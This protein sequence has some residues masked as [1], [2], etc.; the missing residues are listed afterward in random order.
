MATN[1]KKKIKENRNKPI[2]FYRAALKTLNRAKALKK[3]IKLKKNYSPQEKAHITKAFLE[4]TRHKE[5]YQ[6]VSIPRNKG[7]S[8]SHYRKRLSSFQEKWGVKGSLLKGVHVQAPDYIRV[9]YSKGKIITEKFVNEFGESYQ[10]FIPISDPIIYLKDMTRFII[11]MINTYKPVLIWP[12]YHHGEVEYGKSISYTNKEKLIES[13]T[14]LINYLRKL[15][16]QYNKNI[17]KYITGFK[18]QI[19]T[20]AKDHELQMHISGIRKIRISDKRKKK[21]SRKTS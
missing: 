10:L 5:Y 6:F 21:K 1:I 7:E 4:L 13:V 14:D 12:M 16:T 11:D 19:Q 20:G 2:E 9:K 17:L 15:N 18:L 8:K 3:K